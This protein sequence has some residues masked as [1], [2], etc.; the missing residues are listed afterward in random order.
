VDFTYKDANSLPELDKA[1]SD[2]AVRDFLN[3]V[4]GLHD[5]LKIEAQRTLIAFVIKTKVKGS[6]KTKLGD[7][8]AASMGELKTL[9]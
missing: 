2:V 8:L 9:Y 6:A 7:E 3:S 5:A 4:E 1:N